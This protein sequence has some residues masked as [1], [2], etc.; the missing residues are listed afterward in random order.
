[1]PPLHGN[2]MNQ[3]YR[4]PPNHPS[5]KLFHYVN[6]NRIPT[7][8]K[9]M[10]RK[11]G[12]SSALVND[13]AT[14]NSLAI[15]DSLVTDTTLN[16]ARNFAV[17]STSAEITK[18]IGVKVESNTAKVDKSDN[19]VKSVKPV[20]S[21]TS[22]TKED[23]STSKE[24][25]TTLSTTPSTST[26]VKNEAEIS[27]IDVDIKV[28]PIKLEEIKKE[29]SIILT[30]ANEPSKVVVTAPTTTI[31]ATTVE[32]KVMNVQANITTP[33]VS[34]T[35][36]PIDNLKAIPVTDVSKSTINTSTTSKPQ[37]NGTVT[38]ANGA[39]RVRKRH[40]VKVA[41]G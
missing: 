7:N 28:A 19:S 41:C 5:Q 37:S 40:Q 12:S 25:V 31:T 26:I 1:M 14:T 35:T 9:D 17:P 13:I 3:H 29:D 2:G 16:N 30:S 10:Y 8:I 27:K 11:A 38:T 18:Q 6:G 24:I 15:N 32:T 34:V 4:L 23:S 39:V 33:T 36:G 22:I 21:D 20:K